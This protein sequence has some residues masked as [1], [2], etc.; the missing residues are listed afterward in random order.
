PRS[1]SYPIE[2]VQGRAKVL[3][4]LDA[5]PRAPE[6]L[7]PEELR[8]R[9][10][11]RGHALGMGKPHR[12]RER[13]SEILLGGKERVAA[14]GAR[15]GQRRAGTRGKLAKALIQSQSLVAPP[16]ANVCLDE[17]GRPE[18]VVGVPDGLE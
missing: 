14:R 4:S 11:A 3:P 12:V 15:R 2:L 13:F 18:H 10:F 1:R 17:V 8:K 6:P 16:S 7:A 9:G 5:Q